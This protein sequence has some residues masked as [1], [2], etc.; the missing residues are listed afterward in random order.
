MNAVHTGAVHEAPPTLTEIGGVS[1]G[2]PTPLVAKTL[3]VNEPATV[4][5]PESTPVTALSSRPVGSEPLATP[6]VGVGFPLAA[7]R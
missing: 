4:G 6:Y 2:L 7:N 3:K 1:A 5:V